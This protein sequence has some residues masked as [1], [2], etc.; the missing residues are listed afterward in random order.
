MSARPASTPNPAS[1]APRGRDESLGTEKIGKLLARL[2]IPAMIG[3]FV[4]ALYNLVDTIF[5]GQAVGPTGIGG[6]AISFPF[7]IL[8]FAISTMVGIGGAS[9]CSRAL[10]AGDMAKARRAAGNAFAMSSVL[11]LAIMAGGLFFLDEILV[12]FGATPGLIDHARDYLE[13]IVI[14]SPLLIV[15]VTG[16]ILIRSEGRAKVAMVT[17]L[18]GAGANL[19]LDPIF[20][21]GLGMGVRGAAWATVIGFGLSFVFVLGFFL[22]GR[23]SLSFSRADLRIAPAISREMLAVGFPNF[24]KQVGGSVL[25]I[26]AN[27]VLRVHGGDIAIAT[28]GVINRILMFAVMPVFGIVQGFQP[29]AGYNYG[30]R[31][32]ERVREVVKVASIATTACASVFFVAMMAF[33]GPLM[34]IFGDDAELIALGTQAMRIIVLVLPIIGIQ[35]VGATFFMAIG[36]AFPALVLSVSRQILFLIPL[37]IVFPL[38]WGTTGVWL[39]FPV[40]D[41]LATSVT[42]VWVGSELRKLRLHD[43]S[44]D[45]PRDETTG[46][47]A[48]P[49][50]AAETSGP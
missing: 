19:I 5:I 21:F 38:F 27:N 50:V 14:G 13:I 42:I 34:S 23:S 35:L 31:N 22:S 41:T 26:V 17:M 40:A 48:E 39:A 18:I 9:V 15:A 4:N 43:R 8:L 47:T 49:S 36:K 33:P 2:S 29:I 12:A 7:Q 11:A 20:I 16:N 46:S 37:V 3:M 45:R 28:F 1:P 44:F 6:L 24:M 25:V 10:G 32:M 30:A